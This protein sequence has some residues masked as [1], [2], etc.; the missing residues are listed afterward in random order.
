MTLKLIIQE[1]SFTKCF[2]IL[3]KNFSTT[4]SL[5]WAQEMVHQIL[6]QLISYSALGTTLYLLFTQV[7]AAQK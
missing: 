3:P 1:K 2:T 7:L 6:S 5:K 4:F